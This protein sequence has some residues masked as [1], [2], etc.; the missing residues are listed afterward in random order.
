MRASWPLRSRTRN[1]ASHGVRAASSSTKLPST[2]AGGHL[3]VEEVG[4]RARQVVGEQRDGAVG[5]GDPFPEQSVVRPH[6]KVDPARPK[7]VQGRSRR[8]SRPHPRRGWTIDMAVLRAYSGRAVD[9][10]AP[11]TTSAIRFRRADRKNPNA[12]DPVR[13]AARNR[14]LRRQGTGGTPV[15]QR[16]RTAVLPV[17]QAPAVPQAVPEV[18]T[19]ARNH[20]RRA[21][22]GWQPKRSAAACRHGPQGACDSVPGV[23]VEPGSEAS[24]P[25]DPD[26]CRRDPP[27]PGKRGADGSRVP[28]CSCRW[29][30]PDSRSLPGFLT[31]S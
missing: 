11:R 15:V 1:R 28:R 25:P 18:R 16:P 12:R 21:R 9:R 23:C 4:H 6:G 14:Q 24:G 3:G 8:A 5:R 7:R 27:L 20:L 17:L 10:D 22:A 13:A 30:A 19:P 29:C 26:L 2:L 31:A